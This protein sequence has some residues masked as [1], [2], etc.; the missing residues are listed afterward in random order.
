MSS[1]QIPDWLLERYRLGEVAPDQRARVERAMSEDPSVKARLDALAADD[2]QVLAAH[3]PARV[4]ASI[5]AQAVPQERSRFRFVPLVA[6]ALAASVMAVVMTREPADEIRLKGDGPRL[7]LFRMTSKGPHALADGDAAKPGDLVQARYALD[8]P[9][10]AVLLS[11]D[12][13]GS[14]TIHAPPGSDTAIDA[15]SFTTERAF[16]LDDTPGFERFV[17]VTSTSPL[18]LEQLRDAAKA[19]SRTAD[20]RHAPLSIGGRVEQKSIVLVKEAP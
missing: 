7:T 6:A 5:R 18:S 16:E 1:Q 11:F 17:L 10:H 2:A 20:P 8:V 4:A 3:P 12:G 14:V 9:A 15:G 13:A 19:A